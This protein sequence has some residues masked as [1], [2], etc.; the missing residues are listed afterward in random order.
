MR[1]IM[2]AGA[3]IGATVATSAHAETYGKIFGGAVY[4]GDHDITATIPG[5]GTGAGE[6]DTDTG[7]VVGGAYGVN[8]SDF[9]SFEG[10]L[11]Y[12]SNNVDSG[13]VAGVPFDGDG[14]LNALSFMGNAIVKAPGASGFTP[15]VGAGAGLAR[16]GGEG[17][18]DLVF[19]YQAFGGVSKDLSDKLSAGLEYRYLDANEATLTDSLGTINTEYDSHS[20]NLVLTRRF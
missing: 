19:A 1:K 14:D 18:H 2:I 8:A 6:L 15:Y 3:L 12:R 7:F 10:E 13:V 11:A 16:V 17:D 9:L 4:G 20:V 5:V